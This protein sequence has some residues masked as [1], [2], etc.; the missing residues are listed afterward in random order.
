MSLPKFSGVPGC[1]ARTIFSVLPTE[2]ADE[3]YYTSDGNEEEEEEGHYASDKQHR[4][5][6]INY[7]QFTKANST[8]N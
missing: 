1:P 7:Y 3:D 5:S 2:Y 8:H 6:S 4:E